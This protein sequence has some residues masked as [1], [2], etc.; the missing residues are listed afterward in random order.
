MTEDPRDQQPEATTPSAGEDG[1]K[2]DVEVTAEATGDSVEEE[3]EAKLAEVQAQADEYLD[4]WQR[5]RAELDNYR[6]R[7]TRERAQWENMLRGEV[8]TS[9]LP[10]LDDFDLALENL[11]E[12]GERGEWESGVVLIHRKLR[13][14]LEEMGVAEIPA[15]GEEFDPEL[16]DAVMRRKDDDAE[17]GTVIEVVRKG[18]TMG[19]RV[20][21]PAMVIVAE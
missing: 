2:V 6:K 20:L 7:V 5:A 17:S 18:Y 1:H 11:P 13:S 12:E 3:L 15:L 21:R 10:I 16:H 9:L 19:D 8:I 4:G 14:Q